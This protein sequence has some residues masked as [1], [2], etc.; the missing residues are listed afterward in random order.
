MQELRIGP[1]EAG[2]RFD[3]YLR[4]AF[5]GAGSSLLYKQ[6]RKKNITLNNRKAEGSEILKKGDLVR[7]YFSEETYLK[8]RE[9][10]KLRDSGAFIPGSD[11]ETG[12]YERAFALLRGIEVL[13]EDDHIVVLNKPAGVLTQKA[14]PQDLSLNEWL[15]GYLENRGAL[16]AE[17][18]K[19]FHPSVCN[20]LDRNT[21]GLVLCGK[22]LAG[23][24]ALSAL[25]RKRLIQKY[26]RT[27]CHGEITED[28]V[29]EGYLKKDTRS[30]KVTVSVNAQT[31]DVDAA[32][33]QTGYHPL[34]AV[35]SYT[36]LEVELITGKTHQ[37]RA[38]LAFV[39][40]PLIGDVKYGR[41]GDNQETKKRVHLSCHLL[42]ADHVIFP[43]L[44]HLAAEFERFEE[45]LAPLSGKRLDAPLPEAFQ[46][47]LAALSLRAPGSD[48]Q[49][50]EQR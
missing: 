35:P 4:K 38:H 36:F 28:I 14:V 40:H 47:I 45:V 6:L 19:T 7:C 24:Q 41:A 39:G 44:K 32:Y 8:F 12:E 21:S 13:Y 9:E 30:N 20:R 5:P 43:E 50:A 10:V 22:S 31:A 17:D 26:Y 33:I 42:H 25:I 11:V 23:L 49:E 46:K 18:L 1:N 29:L 48:A 3:K 2:Q 27:I 16:S 15:I 34:D 37:I